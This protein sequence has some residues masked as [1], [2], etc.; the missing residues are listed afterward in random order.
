MPLLLAAGRW[1]D[2]TA[3]KAALEAFRPKLVAIELR[4][5]R[6]KGGRRKGGAAVGENWSLVDSSEGIKNPVIR[7]RR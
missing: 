4:V 1:Q 7:Q 6:R 5:C 3:L 2:E